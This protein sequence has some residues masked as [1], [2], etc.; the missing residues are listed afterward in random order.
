MNYLVWI[1]SYG[2]LFTNHFSKF[3]GLM[4]ISNT[5]P[6]TI[7]TPYLGGPDPHGNLQDQASLPPQMDRTDASQLPGELILFLEVSTS[8]LENNVTRIGEIMPFWYF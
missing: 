7:T 8:Y 4:D 1:E 5:L 2:L 6:P 3:P